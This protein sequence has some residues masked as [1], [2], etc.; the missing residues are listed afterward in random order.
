MRQEQLPDFLQALTSSNLKGFDD[1]AEIGELLNQLQTAKRPVLVGGADLLGVS[2]VVAL[3]TAAENLSSKQRT[4]GAMALLA[5]PN[6]F[7]GALLASDGPLF[8]TLLDDIQEGKIKALICLETDPFRETLD[9][10]R[11]QAALGHLEMLVT[12]DFTSSMATQRADI[13]LPTRANAE[14]PGSYINNE[15][16]LQVFLPVIAPGEPIR[17]TGQGDHPPRKFFATTPGS[18]P[19]ADWALLARMLDRTEDLAALRHSIAAND[20]RL[21]A[22]MKVAPESPG[23]RVVFSGNLPPTI[24][25]GLVLSAPKDALSLL[26]ISV[27]VGSHWLAHLS[28][29][30][31]ETEPQPFVLLHPELASEQGL[32]DGD[33]AR[34][35]TH[36]GHCTVGVRVSEQMDKS[37]VLVPQLLGTALEGLV[38]GSICECRLDKEV[39]G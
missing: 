19:E 35:T 14:M 6:S 33:R 18:L 15:G 22:L 23:E 11:A 3:C 34:L 24:E 5:G 36:F 1:K 8:D 7:G 32:V 9:P 37:Q 30:L 20:P 13:L 17:E 25:K 12:L 4:V 27:P 26:A 2:G 28:R 39:G 16:R 38:S 29:P 21:A 10:A 31:A